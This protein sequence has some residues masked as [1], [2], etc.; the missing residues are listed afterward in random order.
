MILFCPFQPARLELA[1][2]IVERRH[3]EIADIE[4]ME[5]GYLIMMLGCAGPGRHWTGQ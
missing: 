2:S 3:L 1:A 4:A 5:A